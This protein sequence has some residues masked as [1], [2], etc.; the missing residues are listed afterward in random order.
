[1]KHYL[2]VLVPADGGGWRAHL[3]DFPGCRAEGVTVETAINASAAA[4]TRQAQE[5][6]TQ[7]VSLPI[8]QTYEDVRCGT[9]WGVERQINWSRAVVS[10]VKVSTD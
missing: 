8:P 7:G 1:M 4:A 10:L 3:P 9:Q 5:L 6:R 2:A